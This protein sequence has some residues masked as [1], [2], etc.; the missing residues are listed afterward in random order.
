MPFQGARSFLWAFRE[1]RQR[2]GCVRD[3]PVEVDEKPDGSVGGVHRSGD[4]AT[5]T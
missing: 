5:A 4:C 2:V 3:G 1:M